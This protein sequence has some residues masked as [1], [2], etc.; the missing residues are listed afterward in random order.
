MALRPIEKRKKIW[1]FLEIHPGISGF[2][3][4]RR[5]YFKKYWTECYETYRRERKY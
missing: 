3:T 1:D 4:F 2:P 5:H